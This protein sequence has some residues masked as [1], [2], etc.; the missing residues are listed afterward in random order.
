MKL[1]AADTA[2]ACSRT[3]REARTCNNVRSVTFTLLQ[4]MLVKQIEGHTICAL[5]DAGGLKCTA[6]TC[7]L[8]CT[9]CTVLCTPAQA[10]RLSCAGHP[11]DSSTSGDE[12]PCLLACASRRCSSC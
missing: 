4:D 10:A 5:G 1:H 7:R 3:V 12:H 8:L 11:C 6:A 2:A 9:A